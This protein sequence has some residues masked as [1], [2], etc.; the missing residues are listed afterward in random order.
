MAP[1]RTLLCVLVAVALLGA[2]RPAVAAAAADPVAQDLRAVLTLGFDDAE[3][4]ARAEP[5]QACRI[6]ERHWQV[7]GGMVQEYST[8]SGD[9]RAQRL[10]GASAATNDTAHI[11]GAD[12]QTQQNL[13]A[14][15]LRDHR[16]GA[17][18]VG[19]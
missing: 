13:V 16:D 1:V 9:H 15:V 4:A 3:A 6:M 18:V 5:A 19:Q 8:R 14:L 10:S 2:H 12:V 11:V 7:F 17:R